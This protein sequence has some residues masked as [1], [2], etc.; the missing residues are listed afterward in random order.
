MFELQQRFR[1]YCSTLGI[2]LP[3][4][5]E[6]WREERPE[7]PHYYLERR[8]KRDVLE[9]AGALFAQTPLIYDYND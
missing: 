3:L 5:A 7:V 6:F 9:K 4:Q 8:P 1:K 2:T